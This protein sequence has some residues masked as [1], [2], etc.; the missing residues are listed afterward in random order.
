MVLNNK[1]V[2][3]TDLAYAKKL[4]QLKD[5]WSEKD[6]KIITKRELVDKLSFSYIKDPIYFLIQERKMEYSK[7][8][9]IAQIL[10]LADLSKDNR[11]NDL[12]NSLLSNGYI[13]NNPYS[14]I[15]YKDYKIYLFEMDEDIEIRNFLNRQKVEFNNLLFSDFSMKENNLSN[16]EILYFKTKY[17]QYNY[18]FSKLRKEIIDGTIKDKEKITILVD[19]EYD[20]YYINM[21]SSIYKID[22]KSILNRKIIF[23][24]KIKEILNKIYKERNLSVV[25]GTNEY[26][27]LVLDFIKKYDLNNLD[28]DFAYL[29][30]VEML[31]AYTYKES[32]SNKGIKATST[33]T[34]NDDYNF[35]TNFRCDSFYKEYADKEVLSDMELNNVGLNTSYIK[36]MLDKRLKLNY[37]KYNNISMISRCE[38]HLS[39]SIFDSQFIE[40]YN[41]KN[42]IKHVLNNE[43]GFYTTEAL[44]LLEVDLYDSAFYKK[45]VINRDIR[46][47]DHTFKKFDTPYITNENKTWSLTDLESFINCPYKYYLNKII[48]LKDDDLYNRALGTLIH[49]VCENIYKSDYNFDLEFDRGVNEFKKMYENNNI[50]YDIKFDSYLEIVRF[51][52]NKF[53]KNIRHIFTSNMLQVYTTKSIL[54]GEEVTDHEIKVPYEIKDEANTY[55]LSGRIDKIVWTKIGNK[56]YYTLFDYKSGKESFNLKEI[57][58]CKSIQLPL[59]YYAIEN[60]NKELKNNGEFGGFGIQHTYANSLKD[61][62]SDDVRTTLS[63]IS[64]LLS[65]EINY[66]Q[67]IGAID[68]DAAKY[69]KLD[70]SFSDKHIS[71]AIGRKKTNLNYTLNDLVEDSKNAVINTIKRIMSN[72]FAIAP[73]PFDITSDS[74][75][76]MSCTYCQYKNVCYKKKSDYKIYARFI[77]DKFESLKNTKAG[78]EDE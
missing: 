18:L 6:I 55:K 53:M 50:A 26:G 38:L 63:K 21:L 27:A 48:P 69:Y 58:L 17:Y 3:I 14:D 47:Y 10:R 73:T 12:Y 7:A 11:L 31:S 24:E 33:F 67:S 59:Y 9:R 19:N 40:E 29:N 71:I 46:S 22:V 15:E 30:L 78:E 20:L 54:N 34:I 41:L 56:H 65:D 51:W 25:D 39:D 5:K 60:Y 66:M 76:F 36:T 70:D 4:Y 8:K 49:T 44:K 35:I 45:Q 37:L 52:L 32:F 28:F 16:L 72:D 74:T 77:K 43:E 75:F 61:L 57:P 1:S 62:F 23:S 68:K 64:G 42:N 2:I 13:K